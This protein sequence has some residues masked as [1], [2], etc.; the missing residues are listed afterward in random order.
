MK[1]A[2]LY[3]LIKTKY[4]TLFISYIKYRSNEF[5]NLK[6][7]ISIIENKRLSD[8]IKAR[9]I[10]TE[11][12]LGLKDPDNIKDFISPVFNPT[13]INSVTTLSDYPVFKYSFNLTYTYTDEIVFEKIDDDDYNLSDQPIFPRHYEQTKT[14]TNNLTDSYINIPVKY[15]YKDY[16]TIYKKIIALNQEVVYERTHISYNHLI[17]IN[18]IFKE[19]IN[20]FNLNEKIKKY[21]FKQISSK[22]IKRIVNI[23]I[24]SDN[25]LYNSTTINKYKLFKTISNK[26]SYYLK[27]Y[28]VAND[29][30]SATP[31]T[32]FYITNVKIISSKNIQVN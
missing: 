18:Y 9:K 24:N 3:T 30:I 16:D 22:N 27:K 26:Y 29:N 31:N 11:R 15:Y 1:K 32:K 20:G 21:N 14:I 10:K 23:G 6:I 28:G 19:D 8:N 25:I 13:E 2:N 12:I 17:K 4:N 5:T 7:I